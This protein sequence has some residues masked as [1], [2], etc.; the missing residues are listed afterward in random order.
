MRWAD[1]LPYGPYL[2]QVDRWV[3]TSK[4]NDTVELSIHEL[5][6]GHA[7]NAYRK[8]CDWSHQP[9]MPLEMDIKRTPLAMALLQ[10]AVGEPV[11]YAD[12]QQDVPITE[13]V[14]LEACFDWLATLDDFDPVTS[15]PITRARA[16]LRMMRDYGIGVESA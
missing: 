8:L 10:R 9:G 12:D 3:S 5:S 16:L 4:D 1:Q 6:P 13:L 14:T 2:G 7:V 11:L 15:H